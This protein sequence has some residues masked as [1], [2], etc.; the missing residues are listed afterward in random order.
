MIDD[1]VNL[2][3]EINN[4]KQQLNFNM[5]TIK[6]LYKITGIS[7][8]KWIKEFTS[9]ENKTEYKTQLLIAMCNGYVDIGELKE[10]IENKELENGIYDLIINDLYKVE[11]VEYKTDSKYDEDISIDMTEN[12]NFESWYNNL[13]YVATVILNKKYKW[14]MNSTPREI[15]TLNNLDYINKKNIIIGAYWNINNAKYNAKNDTNDIKNKEEDVVEIDK[16]TRFDS[17]F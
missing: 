6:N 13:Y 8:F 14:F 15:V 4:K 12:D 16:Y 11:K 5:R 1:R 2:I 10:L 7:L 17:I 9:A 3:V